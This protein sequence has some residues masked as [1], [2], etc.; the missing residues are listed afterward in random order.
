M[1]K[2]G[3]V[4]SMLL[5]DGGWIITGDEYENIQFIECEAITKDEFEA[6]FSQ[7]DAWKAEQDAKAQTDKGALLTKLGIT[8]DEAR[9]LLS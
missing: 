7:Y 2:G 9:L 5:P 1:A 6:G 4:L 8:E 3:D